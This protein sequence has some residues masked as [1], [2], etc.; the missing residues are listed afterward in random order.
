L[1]E[2]SRL[3]FLCVHH[4]VSFGR[5]LLPQLLNLLFQLCNFLAQLILNE[6]LVSVQLLLQLIDHLLVTLLLNVKRFLAFGSELRLH[7]FEVL[8]SL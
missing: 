7:A 6:L 3:L 1:L 4:L 5:K 8:S 2:F